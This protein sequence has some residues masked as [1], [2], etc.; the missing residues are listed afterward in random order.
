MNFNVYVDKQTAARLRRVAKARRIARNALVREALTHFLDR[1][2]Q[3]GWPEVVLNFEGVSTLPPFE[4]T[5][6]NL[7]AP[8]P[9]PFA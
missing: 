2:V 6:N 8:N 7:K 9:D 4:E 1:D 3:A 5:C